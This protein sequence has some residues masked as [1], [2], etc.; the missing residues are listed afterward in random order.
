LSIFDFR[1]VFGNRS[2]WG[3]FDHIFPDTGYKGLEPEIASFSG[4]KTGLIIP[5]WLADRCADGLE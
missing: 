2:Y 1:P 4:R 3:V 5:Y